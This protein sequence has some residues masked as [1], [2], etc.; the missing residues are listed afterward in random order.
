MKRIRLQIQ[1]IPW[2][3]GPPSHSSEVKPWVQPENPDCTLQQ[4]VDNIVTRYGRIYVGRGYVRTHI[5]PA[6]S[7]LTTSR[8]LRIKELQ[9]YWGSTLDLSDKIS[10]IFD[11][12]AASG[13]N[14]TSICKVL[15]YPPDEAELINRNRFASLLPESAARPQKRPPPPLFHETERPLPSVEHDNAFETREAKRRRVESPQALRSPVTMSGE[16]DPESSQTSVI[17]VID[18]QANRHKGEVIGWNTLV[19]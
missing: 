13:E 10:D 14:L 7:E 9:D 15:R 11:D 12:R 17:Q 6:Q 18:S 19:L 1:V 4:L 16:I 5:E 8:P 3:T 2:Q